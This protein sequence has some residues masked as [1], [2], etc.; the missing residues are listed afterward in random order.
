MLLVLLKMHS[1]RIYKGFPIL[2]KVTGEICYK[3]KLIYNNCVNTNNNLL[4]VLICTVT[5]R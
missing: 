1:R 5:C 3:F 4:V 2:C